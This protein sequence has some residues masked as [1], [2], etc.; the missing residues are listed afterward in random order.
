MAISPRPQR[1]Q[2]VLTN[3]KTRKTSETGGMTWNDADA[4]WQKGKL[5]C[6]HIMFPVMGT[7]EH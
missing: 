5:P 3:A 6:L 7:F 1:F 4:Y 2:M